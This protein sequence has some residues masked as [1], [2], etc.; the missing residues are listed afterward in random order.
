MRESIF[1]SPL[2]TSISSLQNW[3]TNGAKPLDSTVFTTFTTIT[4]NTIQCRGW[5]H[6]GSTMAPSG[7]HSWTMLYTLLYVL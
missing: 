1:G 6:A 3:L 5:A 4:T 7:P 2:I